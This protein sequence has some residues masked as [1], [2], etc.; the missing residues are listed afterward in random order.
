MDVQHVSPLEHH[1][2]LPYPVS[3]N[4]YWRIAKRG[5]KTYMLV[6]DEAN[7]YKAEVY[8]TCLKAG[9]R[10]IVEGRVELHIDLYPARPK[11]WQK[12]AAKSKHWA[13][14][15]QCMDLDNVNKVLLDALKGVAFGDDA[16]VHRLVANRRDP[17]GLGARVVVAVRAMP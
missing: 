1:V 11:D 3:A 13:D 7:A 4:R 14:G 12:R 9:I 6:T 8:A 17:D 15:V 10:R 2:T 16:W 5:T